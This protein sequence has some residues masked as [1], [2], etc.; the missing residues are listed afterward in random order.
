MSRSYKKSPCCTDNGKHTTYEKRRANKVVR[1]SKEEVPSGKAYKRFFGSWNIRD[2]SFRYTEHE[3][4][5]AYYR[6]EN[7]SWM[8][9][10]RNADD[11]VN[12]FWRKWYKSK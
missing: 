7:E 10:Y 6:E 3:A 11:F 2:Y 4:R 1:K 5:E 9:K 8:R 12:K